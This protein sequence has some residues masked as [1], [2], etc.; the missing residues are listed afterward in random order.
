MS[1]TTE[2]TT[3]PKQDANVAAQDRWVTTFTGVEARRGTITIGEHRAEPQPTWQS[4]TPSD[5]A[6]PQMQQPRDLKLAEVDAALLGLTQA[7]DDIGAPLG[8]AAVD[9]YIVEAQSGRDALANAADRGEIA[10]QMAAAPAL[11]E[12]IEAARLAAVKDK[13]DCLTLADKTKVAGEALGLLNKAADEIGAPLGRAG[14]QEDIDKLTE[15]HAA[16][17]KATTREAL[18][19]EIETATALPGRIEEVGKAVEK[20]KADCAAWAEQKEKVRLALEAVESAAQGIG[21]PLLRTAID[22]EINA[23]KLKAE[24]LDKA[25]TREA[26]AKEVAAAP[27]LVGEIEKVGEQAGKD[28]DACVNLAEQKEKVRLAMEKLETAANEIGAPLARKAIDEDI[29]PLP[30]KVTALNTA[31]SRDAIGKQIAAAPGLI[32]EI[33]D[34]AKLAAK[35]KENRVKLTEAKDNATK[36]Y[37]LLETAVKAITGPLAKQSVQGVINGID[38][39]REALDKAADRA[40]IDKQLQAA[41]QLLLDIASAQN[42][43]EQAEVTWQGLL[44]EKA[45]VGKTLDTVK[46]RLTWLPG[47]NTKTDFE[48]ERGILAESVKNLDSASTLDGYKNDLAAAKLGADTLNKNVFGFSA[49]EMAASRI[50]KLE[51]WLPV[52]GKV[53]KPN[54][55]S[56]T[57]DDLKN[58]FNAAKTDPNPGPT[59]DAIDDDILDAISYATKAYAADQSRGLY[60]AAAQNKVGG[61]SDT[62]LK[63]EISQAIL[64]AENDRKAA[65]GKPTIVEMRDALLDEQDYAQMLQGATIGVSGLTA[66]VQ[67][68][69]VAADTAIKLLT[70]GTPP[71]PDL[72]KQYKA[73]QKA[74]GDAASIPEFRDQLDELNGLITAALDLVEAARTAAFKEQAKTEDG[75]KKIDELIKTFGEGTDDPV[76]Q[77]ICRAAIGARFNVPLEIP[78]G[79]SVTTLPTIYQMLAMVGETNVAGLKGLAFDTDPTTTASYYGSKKIEL[80]NMRDPNREEG[81][82]DQS[83]PD[84]EVRVKTCK[85]TALHELGHHV[86]EMKDVMGKNMSKAGFGQWKSETIDDVVTAVYTSAFA[87]FVGQ[88]TGKTPTEQDLRALVRSLLESGKAKKPASD[89]DTLGSLFAQW[90][91][92]EGKTGWTICLAIRDPDQ[93]PWEKPV[94]VLGSRAYHEGY[95]NDWYSY[96]TSERAAGISDYQWRSPVEWFAEQFSFYR[97]QPQR[98]KPKS[99]AAYLTM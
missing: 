14:V 79:L 62:N 92:I 8:R 73:I 66:K 47:G 94:E 35:D 70:S 25:A 58:R 32:V 90:A 24:A 15:A 71:E 6:A 77:A 30:S 9:P 89:S 99:I 7:A 60:I 19:K 16:L 20:D 80:N 34:V 96:A 37:A 2:T 26:I 78:D 36:A 40:E 54:A 12:G 46:T 44:V 39:R 5:P 91:N 97:L 41:P 42:A 33:T 27:A 28:K 83:D 57:C 22:P 98:Q 53:V 49:P 55:V 48:K 84:K 95:P 17:G 76:K 86:D 65:Y 81:M 61:V 51:K 85:T 11:L 4:A 87:S 21:A 68:A 18:A 50:K 10:K 13:A 74:L 59:Y 75:K 88:G 31:A 93:D 3:P 82:R 67:T 23:V 45:A 64:D 72:T 63:Q 1:Q 52:F 38:V 69:L 29:K 56:T 43:A